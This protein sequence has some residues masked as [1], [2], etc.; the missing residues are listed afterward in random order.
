MSKLSPQTDKE[1]LVRQIFDAIH[2][3]VLH[4]GFWFGETEHQLGLEK[5]IA[6]DAIVWDR[7]METTIKRLA[8]ATGTALQKGIPETI[9]KLSADELSDLADE[10]SKNWVACDGIWFQ[11]VEQNYDYEMHTTKRIN[12]SNWFRFSNVE[13]NLIMQRFNLPQN[14]GLDI[15]KEALSHRL[16]ARICESE[17]EET[18]G[19]L[20]LKINH[21]RVQDARKKRG[22]ADYNCKSSGVAEYSY[23]A[24]AVN[25]EIRVKCLVCP[26]DPH[27]REY[28]C[29]WEFELQA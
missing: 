14:G 2:L 10:M 28:W 1:A 29:A 13:A 7:V 5:A 11:S 18:P 24:A 12:D 25:P 6:A 26:P 22:L 19:K 23:F 9:Q 16:Y 4:Y 3:T 27:P 15:L 20:I 21:C 17:F 8:A